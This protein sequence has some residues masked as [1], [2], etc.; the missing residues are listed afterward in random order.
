MLLQFLRSLVKAP[1]P[2]PASHSP[3]DA[4]L[5]SL[6][7]GV[8]EKLHAKEADNYDADRYGH[9]GVDRSHVFDVPY[10]YQNLRYLIYEIDGLRRT[11]DL[12]ESSTSKEL[13]RMLLLFRV[14]GHMHVR[15]PTNR[16]EHWLVRNTAKAQ[17]RAPSRLAYE[18]LFGRLQEFEIEF[19]NRKIALD[20]WW[21]N[22]AWTFLFRQYYFSRDGA[23]IRP[24]PGDHVIDAGSCFGDTALAFATSVGPGGRVYSFEM[25]LANLEVLRHNLQ[26]N[27]DLAARIDVVPEALGDTD[28]SRLYLH[29]QGPGAAVSD[30]PSDQ[31][32]TVATID[33]FVR[34]RG[35]DRIDFIKMDIEGAE[36]S[37]LRGAEQTIR[38][39]RPKLAISIYHRLEHFA[40]VPAWIDDLHLGYRFYL[41]HYTIH[42]E[43]SIVYA[44]AR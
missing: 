3:P 29:G 26:R 33:A 13:F 8:W 43:E 1:A 19:E 34:G 38:R 21:L 23:T 32:V 37:A 17:A 44:S 24:E 35:I 40:W 41:D 31:P 12:L 25:V 22:V 14:L 5:D 39:D 18:G 11:F 6:L 20:C 10:A 15:L 4:F 7:L 2:A 16:P 27:P 28:G 36:F 42:A 30:Q 9:D